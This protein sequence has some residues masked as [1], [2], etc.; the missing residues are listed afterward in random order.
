MS[1]GV[2]NMGSVPAKFKVVTDESQQQVPYS[3]TTSN[4]FRI[5]MRVNVKDERVTMEKESVIVTEI[6]PI[7]WCA[8]IVPNN[9]RKKC[10]LPTIDDILFKLSKSSVFS[11]LDARSEYWQIPLDDESFKYTTFL[12]PEG[13]YSYKRLPFGVSCASEIFE[14]EMTVIFGVMDGVRIIQGGVLIHGDSVKRHDS[15]LE[16]ENDAANGHTPAPV[17]YPRCQVSSGQGPLF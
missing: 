10:T 12:M 17:P 3:V 15:L 6:E 4:W 8:P 5:S 13:R 7:E 2:E 1:E 9:V 14:W 11:Q 16:D